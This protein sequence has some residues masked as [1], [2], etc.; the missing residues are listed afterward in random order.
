MEILLIAFICLLAAKAGFE[1]YLNLLN[2]RHV[3]RHA[4]AIPDAL[5]GVMDEATY[6]KANAYTLAKLRFGR[7]ESVTDALVLALV[8]ASGLLVWLYHGFT[9]Y[10]GS[11]VWGQATVLFLIGVLLSIPALPLEWY[12]VFRL[13]E[14]FGF[15]KTTPGTWIS[16][17]IKGLLINAAIMI[18]LLALL[19]FLVKRMPETWWILGFGVFFA[20]S[21]LMMV[22]YPMLIVPLFNKLEPLEDGELKSRLMALAERARFHAE[23]IQVIDGSKRSAHSN[24]YFTGFGRFRRIVLFDTLMEQLEPDEIEAVLAHEI[25]HYRLGHIPKMLALSAVSGLIGF[26]VIAWLANTPGFLTGFGFPAESGIGAVFL[27]FGLVSGTFTFWLTPLFARW[28]RKY[29]YEADAFAKKVLDGMRSMAS[30]LRKLSEKNL[31]NL[32]PHPL[33]SAWYYSHPTLVERESALKS[34]RATV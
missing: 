7:W 23:T 14:R 20:F 30:A 12:E 19:F 27:L 4:E 13:E 29:E 9:G 25:G 8:L 32:T 31:S 22:L 5:E 33:Y 3:R 21:I 2:A 26:A 1:I 28:S 6:R 24:A 15:N 17:K 16:D 34:D 18:P 11:G 10:L